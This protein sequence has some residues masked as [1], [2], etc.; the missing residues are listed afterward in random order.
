MVAGHDISPG[1]ELVVILSPL[2]PNSLAKRAPTW[3]MHQQAALFF[4]LSGAAGWWVMQGTALDLVVGLACYV[5][6]V[7]LGWWYLEWAVL[8]LKDHLR[9]RQPLSKGSLV[10]IVRRPLRLWRACHRPWITVIS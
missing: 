10:L 4:A 2:P 7:S 8:R 6:S 3:A 5:L 9:G 1:P